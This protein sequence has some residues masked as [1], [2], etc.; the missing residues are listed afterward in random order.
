MERL[1]SLF[2]ESE[3]MLTVPPEHSIVV[4][5]ASTQS[6]V[7][8]SESG[9]WIANIGVIDDLP[10]ITS[11]VAEVTELVSKGQVARVIWIF[12][13]AFL[14]P[15]NAVELIIQMISHTFEKSQAFL[16]HSFVIPGASERHFAA[17]RQLKINEFGVF[18]SGKNGESFIEVH[19]PDGSIVVGMPG[20]SFVE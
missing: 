4:Y 3:E 15:D 8:R 2:D 7:E 11:H 9:R 19:R 10:A 13:A 1:D 6:A 16:V 17:M 20:R 18:H 14:E 12:P 5:S